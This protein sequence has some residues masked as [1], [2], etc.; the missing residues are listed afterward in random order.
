MP[1]IKTSLAPHNN[2]FLS[3][4]YEYMVNKQLCQRDMFIDDLNY[5]SVYESLFRET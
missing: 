2:V 3:K 5:T 1:L 4:Y